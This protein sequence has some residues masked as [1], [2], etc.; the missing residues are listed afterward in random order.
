MKKI[1]SRLVFA[2]ACLSLSL[3]ALA[4]LSDSDRKFVA[5]AAAAGNAEIALGRIAAERGADS[6]VRDFGARMAQ[7]HAQIAASLRTIAAAQGF[8]LREVPTDAQMAAQR[9]L[10]KLRGPRFDD[11]YVRLQRTEQDKVMVLFRGESERG[12]DPALRQFAADTLVVIEGHRKRAE[13][14]PTW[15]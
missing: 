3:P 2:A 13:M 7:D 12:D 1:R 6:V 14:L 5:E 11:A 10:E 15:R 9:D 4:L 8:D